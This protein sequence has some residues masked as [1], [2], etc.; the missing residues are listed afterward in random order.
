MNI[1]CGIVGLPNV[2]KSTL[3]NALLK[4]QQAYVANFP[5]ATIEP[6]IGVIPV[7]D[8]RLGKLAE[9]TKKAENM[10]NLPPE[11][12]ATVEFVDIAGLIAGASKGEGLGNKFLSHIRETSAICHVVRA[13]S[14]PDIIKQGVADPKTDFE[15]VETELTLA[16]F[17]TLE[18]QKDPGNT[19]DKELVKWWEVVTRLKNELQKGTP[20]RDVALTEEEEKI[21]KSLSLLTAKPI[22][23]VLNVDES[24]LGDV[25]NLEAKYAEE[26]KV[27][28][29][30]IVA[31]CAKTESE[32]SELS[33][34]DQKIYMKD[35]GITGSGLER[36]IQ[37]AFATLGLITFLT[38]GEKEVRAWTIKDGIN[39]QEAAGVIHTDFIKKFIKADV[40][41]FT[42]F[43]GN[44]GWK[45]CREL[46][47]VRS[48]GRDYTIKDGDVVEFKIGT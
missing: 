22:L 14:D 20:A 10:A 45:I 35:L 4:R 36:L 26:L 18:K 33:E 6:N 23:I 48:E 40:V 27:D 42:D 41:T 39:A 31:I 5:F 37:K 32:L 34:E 44:G 28:K 1:S 15:V 8:G 13:F 16:D 47:K 2:G 24:S 43:V 25:D 46:G 19:P 30:Q 21:A 11:I 7:P 9:V 12:P 3:F 17:Q 38:A 29:N